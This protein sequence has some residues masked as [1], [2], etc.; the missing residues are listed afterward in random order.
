[1]SVCADKMEGRMLGWSCF[2]VSIL[3]LENWDGVVYNSQLTYVYTKL[4]GFGRAAR[5]RNT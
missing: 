3:I 1:M 5:N 4:E 2:I